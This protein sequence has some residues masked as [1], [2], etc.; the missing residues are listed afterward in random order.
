VSTFRLGEMT[1]EEAGKA[2]R[3]A[4]FIIL[5]LGSFEQH[6]LHLPL[7]TDS[8]RAEF[9]AEEVAK[10]A[11]EEGLKVLVLPTLPY[12]VS[13]H[14]MGFPGTISID[15]DVYIE[16]IVCIGRS[17]AK[18]GAKRL[19]LMNFHGGNLAP[20]Q[21]AM[22]K[23]RARYGLRTYL[24]PWTS[25]AR[26]AIL[27]EL[28]PEKHWGHACEH[29]TSMIMLFRPELVKKEKMRK[30]NVRIAIDETSFRMVPTFLYF[31]EITD[32]G[33][34]GDPLKASPEK[35]RIIIE[36]ANKR[37]VEAMKRII[38]MEKALQIS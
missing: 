3:E 23:I 6:A 25:F 31:N 24:F 32:T 2:I 26:D 4:D 11:I 16:F 21:I 38:E 13:E 14:H 10:K 8:I 7:L 1:W 9:L 18:H 30:P 15:P 22:A 36:E 29:E 34:L 27:R 5:P 35:A 33:G 28:K 20:L 12:G 17:L 37:I 19:I